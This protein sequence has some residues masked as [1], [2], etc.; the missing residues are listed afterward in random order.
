MAAAPRRLGRLAMGSLATAAVGGAG[1][2]VMYKQ[3]LKDNKAVTAVDFNA[4]QDQAKVSNALRAAARREATLRLEMYRYT[5]C[6][7]C[8]KVKAFLDYFRIPH[9]A[10]EVEP[11]FKSQLKASEYKKLPQLRFGGDDGVWLVDSDCIVDAMSRA[12]GLESQLSDPE[13]ERWR[14]WARESLVRH[15]TLNINRSL[16]S[17]WQGYSYIDAFDTI[18]LVNKLFL[19]VVG[20][21][22]MYMVATKKTYP[23][24]VKSGD[25]KESDDWRSV[26]HAQVNRFVDEVPLT[27]KRPFHGGQKPDLADLDV[28]GV[29]QS[30]RGHEVYRDML[31]NTKISDW[32]GRMDAATGKTSE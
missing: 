7:Y 5:T 31:E 18:P 3:R 2:Y 20:A 14:S 25:L 29:L 6:P 19:K 23:T 1:G 13:I 12:M 9:E 27:K 30:I 32:M 24:L 22:V 8:G 16:A 4:A 17:A 28:Y 21:P 15:V 26:F 11:M 10:V